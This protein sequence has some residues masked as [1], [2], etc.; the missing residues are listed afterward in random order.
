MKVK[1]SLPVVEESLEVLEELVVVLINEAV[2]F[3]DDIPGVMFHLE[4]FAK[5]QRL[6]R[7]AQLNGTMAEQHDISEFIELVY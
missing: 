4:V 6:V 7:Q 3:I 1:S 5:L 2:H